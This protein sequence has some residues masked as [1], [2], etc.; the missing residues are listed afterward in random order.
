MSGHL[1]SGHVDCTG[2][3]RAKRLEAYQNMDVSIVIPDR[4]T[5]YVCEKGSICLDGVSLTVKSVRGSVV[6][7][8]LIPFTLQ[9][10]IVKHWRV[11][12][13]VNVEVDQIARYLTPKSWMNGGGKA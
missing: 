8:T 4:V 11:G 7:V 13:L 2:T 6:V 3:V 10:T 1:V 5:P 9:T 12:T